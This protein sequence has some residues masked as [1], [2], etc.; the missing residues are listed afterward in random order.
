M[1]AHVRQAALGLRWKSTSVYQR[2]SFSRKAGI[3]P[4]LDDVERISRGQAAKRRGTGSRAVP[5]RL[6]AEE[7]IEWDNA[8][9]R[10]F[11]Q[12]RG[13]GWRKE[14]GDSPL[15]NSFRNFCDATSIPYIS[16][17]K[18]IGS[19]QVLLDHVY[20]DFSPLRSLEIE[21]YKNRCLEIAKK[22]SSVTS[23]E[24]YTDPNTQ[25]WTNIEEMLAGLAIWSIPTM[26][27][28]I[29]FSVRKEAKDFAQA[30]I[31][32]FHD[33]KELPDKLTEGN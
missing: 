17:E 33:T 13:S 14:R 23:V 12:L 21:G 6:N 31:D 29:S 4:S 7:R 15:A 24:D 5:H 26:A 20:I 25:G 27:L 10:G 30:V 16:I 32:A 3:R 2:L 18:G 19:S 11:V 22:F 1:L 28:V 8:K 9:K